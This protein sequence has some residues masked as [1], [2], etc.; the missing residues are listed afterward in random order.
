MAPWLLMAFGA[1]LRY[2]LSNVCIA[3]L[4]PPESRPIPLTCGVSFACA[5]LML[6]VMAVTDNWWMF[7][8]TMTDGDWALI[9]T[10]VISA[11]FLVLAFEIIRMAGPVFLS[12][13]GYFGT[14]IGL[15]WAAFYFAET[16]SPWIWAA[17]A[18]LFFGQFLVNRTK[19]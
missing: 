5:I 11:I 14:L 10:M 2:A 18:I 17:T 3:I 8:A 19:E 13:Y 9:G 6:P 15:G 1:P 12:T 4:R 16:P 7:D